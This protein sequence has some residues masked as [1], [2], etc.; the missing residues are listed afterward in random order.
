MQTKIQEP[1]VAI[2]WAEDFAAWL[3]E[4]GR[5]AKTIE[6]YL[7]DLRHWA[8][9]FQRINGQGFAPELMN[10]TDVKAYF[11]WQADIKAAPA[12]RNRRLASL[13]VLVEWARESGRLDYDPTGSI[14]R[15]RQSKLPPRAKTGPEFAQLEAVA[16]AG[17]HLKRHTELYGVLGVRD[18]VVWG[19]FARAGLRIAEIA[20]LDLADLHLD[21]N[22]IRVKGKGGVIGEVIIPDELVAEIHAWLKVRPGPGVSLV[23]DWHGGRI[24]TGQIRRRVQ[25]IGETAGVKVSPHD[26]RHTY[27]YRLLDAFLNDGV[28]LPVA[29]DAVRQ[30]ARHGSAQTTM[31]YLR[32]RYED[33]RSAVEAM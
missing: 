10:A 28:H 5:A 33:I 30:Q 19:L 24:T 8:R 6:A 9:F 15:A 3:H 17:E 13:R 22:M 2:H 23:T 7:Q 21:E 14:R 1:M 31:L 27:V 32:A 11:A 16:T 26:L 12:S 4:S 20:G 25:A 18:Q 29:L